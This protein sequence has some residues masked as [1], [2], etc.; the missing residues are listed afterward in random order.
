MGPRGGRSPSAPS[1]CVAAAVGVAGLIWAA[2]DGPHT[3]AATPVAT[4]AAPLAEVKAVAKKPAADAARRGA[5]LQAG[6]GRAA[7][8]FGAAKAIGRR[9]SPA[10]LPTSTIVIGGDR[11]IQTPTRPPLP[12]PPRT[13]TKQAAVVDG[14]PAG[15]PAI[16][17]ARNFSGAFVVF[18]TGGIDGDGAQVL[19]G[20]R[21]RRRW[22]K[23]LLKRPPRLPAN[24]KVPKAKVLNI[25]AGASHGDVYER[26]ASRC[27]GSA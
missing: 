17:V 3:S 18:E 12:P 21:R 26:S 15:T 24:V 25:V 19:R 16:A 14:A 8:K 22:R 9:P 20:P 27:C 13:S 5:G 4:T 23:S 1:S 6:P 2:P 11:R 7:L 10:A